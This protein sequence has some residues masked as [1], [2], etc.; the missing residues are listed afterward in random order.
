MIIRSTIFRFALWLAA[1]AMLLSV[2]APTISRISTK[3]DWVE[4][5]SVVGSK[6]V[7][8]VAN[9]DGDQPTE[10]RAAMNCP[11]CA[12]HIDL[13]LPSP[14]QVALIDHIIRL[15]FVPRLLLQAP[16]AQFVWAPAQSRAPPILA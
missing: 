2:L 7:R 3:S 9:T 10:S 12:L 6:L 13:A 4:V 14:P 11:Y 15:A 5:C 1:L 16:R 8:V